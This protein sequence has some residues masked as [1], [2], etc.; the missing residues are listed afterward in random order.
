MQCSLF[1]SV[2]TYSCNNKS[3][4][5][6][7]GNKA[8]M[9]FTLMDYLPASGKLKVSAN[10]FSPTWM[11]LHAEKN[12]WQLFKAVS[13]HAFTESG[14]RAG[15]LLVAALSEPALDGPHVPVELLGQALQPLLIRVLARE[16]TRSVC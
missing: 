5:T 4:N 10:S 7:D 3:N 13:S 14:E 8:D 15:L 11:L 16:D 9:T 12:V 1:K 6:H 2:F